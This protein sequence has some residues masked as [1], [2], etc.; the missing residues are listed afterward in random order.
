MFIAEALKSF[1]YPFR[2]PAHTYFRNG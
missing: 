1:P 2:C